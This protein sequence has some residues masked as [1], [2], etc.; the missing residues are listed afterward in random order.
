M[1]KFTIVLSDDEDECRVGTN[2]SSVFPSSSLTRDILSAPP[3]ELISTNSQMNNISQEISFVSTNQRCNNILDKINT[4]HVAPV[5][6]PVPKSDEE[7]R[8]WVLTSRPPCLYDPQEDEPFSRCL[9]K[10]D[11]SH[12]FD[13]HQHSINRSTGHFN[14]GYDAISLGLKFSQNTRKHSTSEN[15]V[16]IEKSTPVKEDYFIDKQICGNNN[17][18]KRTSSIF[19]NADPMKKSSLSPK[20]TF[21]PTSNGH[22]HLLEDIQNKSNK[23]SNTLLAKYPKQKFFKDSNEGMQ[24]PLNDY[25][26]ESSVLTIN[27]IQYVNDKAKINR[28]SK[29]FNMAKRR[30]DIAASPR[31]QNSPFKFKS[32]NSCNKSTFFKNNIADICRNTS[33]NLNSAHL[34]HSLGDIGNCES[35]N[36]PKRNKTLIK[37]K[38]FFKQSS[39]EMKRKNELEL[40]TSKTSSSSIEN[41]FSD[42]QRLFKKSFFKSSTDTDGIKC[43]PMSK[44]EDAAGFSEC[45]SSASSGPASSIP[46]AQR[47]QN[48]SVVYTKVETH[49]IS[50]STHNTDS[51]Y[52]STIQFK[53]TTSFLSEGQ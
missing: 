9:E 35:E 13:T 40:N 37:K 47:E 7:I 39:E 18:W 50:S 23:R 41:I 49:Y 11:N 45:C 2:R 17:S 32:K 31:I 22:H 21:P 33:S 43:A 6:S 4:E 44:I 14:T 19:E 38:H 8:F 42:K 27:Y 28:K 36:I 53:Q 26:S 29:S 51:T 34:N 5:R 20:N 52:S 3:T 12:R 15:R 24:E 30:S 48:V 10:T 46:A 1:K 16:I 25:D